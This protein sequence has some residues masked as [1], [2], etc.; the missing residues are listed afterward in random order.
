[1]AGLSA[2]IIGGTGTINKSPTKSDGSYFNVYHLL[3][4]YYIG[5]RRINISPVYIYDSLQTSLSLSKTNVKFGKY[6]YPTTCSD[7][8]LFYLY[9]NK[10]IQTKYLAVYNDYILIGNNKYYLKKTDSPQ[11]FVYKD[12]NDGI[13]NQNTGLHVNVN[14]PIES[15]T[16]SSS[17]QSVHIRNINLNTL[18]AEIDNYIFNISQKI[19]YVT[20]SLASNDMSP[21]PNNPDILRKINITFDDSL[22]N[23]IG[24]PIGVGDNISIPI[25]PLAQTLKISNGAIKSLT[26]NDS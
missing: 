3:I 9:N 5:D 26:I 14:V 24:M 4:P 11:Y 23:I 17:E 8:Y 12:E 21:D 19:S 20:I 16:A 13:K 10:I 25:P 15:T 7:D 18:S 2:Q 1:M 6:F 22:Y